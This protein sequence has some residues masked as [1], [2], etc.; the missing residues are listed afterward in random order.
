MR[1]GSLT[2][3][4]H[5]AGVDA[6]GSTIAV[7]VELNPDFKPESLEDARAEI[8]LLVVQPRP[9]GKAVAS[10]YVPQGKLSS[11][12]SKVEQYL[13][14]SKDSPSGAPRNAPM[15][16][17]VDG[18]RPPMARDLWS[19]PV[20]GF[21]SDERDEVWWEVWLRGIDA[22][23]FRAH[24]GRLGI[25]V[26]R[27]KL[28]FPERCVVVAKASVETI[29][30]AVELLDSIAELRAAPELDAEFYAM[31]GPEQAEWVEE[32]T[33]RL[34]GPRDDD[35]ALCLL[36]TG[37]AWVHPLLAPAIEQ[38]DCHAYDG[39]SPADTI[40]HGTEMAGIGCYGEDLA[41]A[42]ADSHVV[43]VPFRLESV[44]VLERGFHDASLRL[45]GEILRTAI[46]LV[47][48]EKP[49]RSRVFGFTITGAHSED[50]RPTAWS[51]A[52][53]EVC[54]GIDD[55]P[56]RLVCVSAGTVTCCTVQAT[57]TRRSTCRRPFRTPLSPGMR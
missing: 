52:L 19:D 43:A 5:A 41:V 11:P 38:E 23:R 13:D 50:G 21:P 17:S 8:E 15:I 12:K 48:I 9:H 6:T 3:Q 36:D 49:D 14:S 30:R 51:A 31:D 47:D 40:G 44:K 25:Q 45:R 20:Y 34:Q 32:T 29:E 2:H 7:D 24:A 42:L 33:A 22:T 16:S 18:Y 46:A 37:V 39:W 57:P 27:Q 35:L 54:A 56:A 28:V 55:E 1:E 10:V 26:G 4:R 53:D